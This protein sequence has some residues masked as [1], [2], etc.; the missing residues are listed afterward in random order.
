MRETEQEQYRTST[1]RAYERESDDL[2]VFGQRV[3]H[4]VYYFF[5]KKLFL[6]RLEWSEDPVGSAVIEGFARATGCEPRN[7]SSGPATTTLLRA[8]G[9]S[10]SLEARH[11]RVTNVF[12]GWLVIKRKGSEEAIAAQLRH[13]ASAQF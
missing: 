9:K 2:N 6:V 8:E 3:S 1:V 7:V 12:T 11:M 4:I 5:K 10:V 13:E